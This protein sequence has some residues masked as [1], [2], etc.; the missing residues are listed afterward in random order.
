MFEGEGL[1]GE[2]LTFEKDVMKIKTNGFDK[3]LFLSVLLG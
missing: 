2:G 1:A 3:D